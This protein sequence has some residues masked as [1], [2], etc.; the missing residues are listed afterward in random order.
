MYL[1]VHKNGDPIRKI[2]KIPSGGASYF[3]FYA[4]RPCLA[5]IKA[6][7]ST[8]R[9]NSSPKKSKVDLIDV[10]LSGLNFLNLS[11][12]D[13]KKEVEFIRLKQNLLLNLDKRGDHTK[14]KDYMEKWVKTKSLISNE[15]EINLRKPNE[16]KVHT[17]KVRYELIVNPNKHE[18]KNKIVKVAKCRK[19]T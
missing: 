19:V 11:D 4:H 16:N 5:A 6:F 14:I 2:K 3:A 15:I 17:Y 12:G 18:I 10:N 7:N 9:R 8:I 1:L 13:D